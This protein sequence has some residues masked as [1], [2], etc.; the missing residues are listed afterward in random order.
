M[1]G[2][3]MRKIGFTLFSLI[4][5]TFSAIGNDNWLPNAGFE[6]SSPVTAAKMNYF[7]SRSLQ[8]DPQILP[9]DWTVTAAGKVEFTTGKAGLK[10]T[11]SGGKS[12]YFDTPGNKWGSVQLLCQREFSYADISGNR[13][14][15]SLRA[16]GKGTLLVLANVESGGQKNLFV[17]QRFELT[18]EWQDLNIRRWNIPKR[19]YDSAKIGF[20]IFGSGEITA[21]EVAVAALGKK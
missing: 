9:E 13:L 17:L 5:A 18:G 14:A 16:K 3:K 8:I 11:E 2:Y 21:P 7:R 15:V 12:F 19:S 4:A 20:A 6:K 10:D 1:K